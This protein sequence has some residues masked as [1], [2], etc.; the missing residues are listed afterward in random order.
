MSAYNPP[1]ED[2]PIFD[3]NAFTNA[4]TGNGALV[5]E[6]LQFPIAQGVETFPNGL[7]GNLTGNSTAITITSD[8]STGTYYIPF[9]KTSG[10]GSKELFMDDATGPLT[11]NP[12]TATLTATNITGTCSAVNVIAGATAGNYYLTMVSGNTTGS[13]TLVIDSTSAQDLIYNNNT[14]SLVARNLQSNS[15]YS[16]S[17]ADL[18]I[19][20]ATITNKIYFNGTTSTNNICYMDS[21]G[22]TMA[23]GKIIT[24]NLTGTCSNA[25]AITI[26]SDNSDGAYF[27]PFTKT[28]GTGSRT[29]FMDD[30][31]INLPLTYNPSLS[32][33]TAS[34]F[35]GELTGS[36]TGGVA[37]AVLYQVGANTSAFTT[38]GTSGQSLLSAGGGT[39]TWGIPATAT[40]ASTASTI[41]LTTDDTSGNYFL[42]FSKFTAGTSKSLFIDDTTTPLTY[43]PSTS[44]LTSTNFSGVASKVLVSPYVNSLNLNIALTDSSNNL[45][46]DGENNILYNPFTNVL[47]GMIIDGQFVINNDDNN[48]SYHI[49]FAKTETTGNK[50]L[51]IDNTTTPLTYNPYTSTITSTNFSGTCS[52]SSAITLTTDD[53]SGNYFLTFSKST[54]GISKSLYIDD[55][56]TPLIYNPSTSNLTCSKFTGDLV[57]TSS[58]LTL[59][60]IEN[61]DYY[62]LPFT[63]QMG[64]GSSTLYID[65]GLDIT[66]NPLQKIL[67]V[68]TI[69]A[70]TLKS[71]SSFDLNLKCGSISNVIDFYSGD[72]QLS[73]SVSNTK[74]EAR[75]GT[76]FFGNIVG[77]LS[78]NS[79]TSTTTTNI[80]GG[81]E[82]SIPLQTASGATSF[83]TGFNTGSLPFGA[84]VSVGDTGGPSWNYN[85][86][87]FLGFNIYNGSR[88]MDI[89]V[90]T[91]RI[92]IF[93]GLT[94]NAIIDLPYGVSV[95]NGAVITIVN[96]NANHSLTVKINNNTIRI[97][98]T[99]TNNY[100]SVG[101]TFIY[102][103]RNFTYLDSYWIC[104][105]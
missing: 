67:K 37:G 11:Y 60:S 83:I 31:A 51:F 17:T 6:Y 36:I 43:N 80:A 12:L 46:R 23:T 90:D 93:T 68:G 10:T 59:T 95:F 56:T 86:G 9:T 99:A 58:K 84:T 52:T 78:G 13:K 30:V 42:T 54:S 18:N 94:T 49:P 8:N 48:V 53:T 79:T 44:T 7:V 4:N 65:T 25:S 92:N 81:Y 50:T 102:V 77:D 38:A 105:N 45:Y 69:N 91:N 15:L 34:K 88:S 5:S 2:L 64:T 20:T 103:Y 26:T 32:T 41:T 101:A 76:K 63:N 33:L 47:S 29:L 85:F 89:A 98:P 104:I 1:I 97:I 21:T 66:Y 57:G 96:K 61:D 22:L 70:E 71:S 24:G 55:T 73:M 39:P 3:T 19:A 100:N 40:S 27:I 14:N 87:T 72:S 82:N 75:G 16:I 28:I 35:V 62:N 74:I